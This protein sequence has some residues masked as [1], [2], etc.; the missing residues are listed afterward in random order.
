MRELVRSWRKIRNRG[1]T[2]VHGPTEQPGGRSFWRHQ[3]KLRVQL[4]AQTGRARSESRTGISDPG[5]QFEALPSSERR[6]KR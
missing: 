6:E 4:T 1:R 5:L 3:K 2:Q